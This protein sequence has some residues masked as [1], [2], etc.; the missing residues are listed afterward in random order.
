MVLKKDRSLSFWELSSRSQA[1]QSCL[2]GSALLVHPV[3]KPKT[4][5]ADQEGSG[6]TLRHLLIGKEHACEDPNSTDTIPGLQQ[7]G[8]TV[9]IKT[10]TYK[11]IHRL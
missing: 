1:Q 7:G 4:S 9:P 3:I 10:T 5:E 6:T 2:K 11:K 8:S